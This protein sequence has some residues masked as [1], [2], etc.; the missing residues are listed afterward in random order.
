MCFLF[1]FLSLTVFFVPVYIFSVERVDQNFHVAQLCI[2]N[3]SQI[4]LFSGRFKNVSTV[5][6]EHVKNYE[7]LR[8]NF[9][10]SRSVTLTTIHHI[11]QLK[12]K[13]VMRDN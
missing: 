1:F 4:V 3:C 7:K 11:P 8:E 6:P 5:F 13:K 12:K 2:E 10:N 9:E